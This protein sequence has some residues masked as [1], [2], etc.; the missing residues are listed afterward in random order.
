[1]A[2]SPAIAR[3]L[4]KGIMSV[5]Y[6]WGLRKRLGVE[7]GELKLDKRAQF[8]GRD[9]STTVAENPECNPE[10]IHLK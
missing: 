10:S 5:S 1:M 2:T 8:T 9:G 6:I 4:F 3:I 7:G